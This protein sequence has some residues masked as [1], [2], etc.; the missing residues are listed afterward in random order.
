MPSSMRPIMT[1]SGIDVVKARNRSVAMPK[2]KAI[3]TPIARQ[4]A[5]PPTRKIRMLPLPNALSAGVSNQSTKA[6]A[7]TNATETTTS[8]GL[9]VL[10]N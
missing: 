10:S 6:T 1:T 4:T 3:G 9:A 5:A 2:Q 7:S 8:S